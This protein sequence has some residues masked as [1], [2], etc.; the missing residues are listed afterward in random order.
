MT[1][2]QEQAQLNTL[3]ACQPDELFRIPNAERAPSTSARSLMLLV[4]RG[5]QVS[6]CAV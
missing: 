4:R 2:D 6:G 5:S 1:S 3:L